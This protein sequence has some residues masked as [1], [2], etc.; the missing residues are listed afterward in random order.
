[1]KRKVQRIISILA[2]I[3][4]VF[5]S[6]PISA[7]ADAEITYQ[8]G[9]PTAIA[10]GALTPQQI[11]GSAVEFGVVANKYKQ[12]GHTETNFAVKHFELD[13]SQSIEIMGSGSNPIP[14]YIGELDGNTYFW[15]GEATNVT[16]DVFINKD[17]SSKGPTNSNAKVRY[18]RENPPTNV[19]PMEKNKIN[20]YVDTLLNYPVRM[21]QLMAQ[22][23]TYTPTFPNNSKTIDLTGPAF[24]Q[25]KNATI[26]VDCTNMKNIMSQDGW[27]I[28]KYEGQTIV[29]NMPDGG[30]YDIKKFKVTVK[31][32]GG[33]TVV[34]GLESRTV[35]KN[36]DPSHNGNVERYILNHIVFNAPNASS[37]SIDTAAGIFLAPNATVNQNN[38]AGA[39]W[40]VTKKDFNSTAEWHYYFKERHYHANSEKEIN[41][42]KNFTYQDGTK[43][44]PDVANKQ[45]TFKMDEVDGNTFQ[46]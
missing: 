41:I 27:E 43:L 38:G 21:S 31:N 4:M 29:F 10:E 16:F 11:L 1:M 23:S 26:Y 9:L 2:S 14:F 33:G 19:Y 13:N 22:K 15:N 8:G 25:A 28:I 32:E 7:F 3:L 40:V 12:K 36:G 46:I 39:G 30:N 17:Q 45:G 37:L 6:V 35:E 5:N 24:S 42:S 44:P 18:S 34:S 20:S